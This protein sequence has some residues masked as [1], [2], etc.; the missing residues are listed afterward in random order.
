MGGIA[1]VRVSVC[2]G[3]WGGQGREPGTWPGSRTCLGANP[4]A[5]M[6]SDRMVRPDSCDGCDAQQEG[7]EEGGLETPR[8]PENAGALDL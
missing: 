4:A 8:T 3:V 2:V 6:R 1:A 7:W 5:R